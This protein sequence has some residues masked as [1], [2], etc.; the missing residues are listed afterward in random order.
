[1]EYGV[2]KTRFVDNTGRT[3]HLVL[4]RTISALRTVEEVF[5]QPTDISTHGPGSL[6]RVTQQWQFETRHVDVV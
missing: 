4:G 1:M 3:C 6:G 2:F 5:D